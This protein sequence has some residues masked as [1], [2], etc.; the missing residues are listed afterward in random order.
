MLS[1]QDV[2]KTTPTTQNISVKTRNKNLSND[3]CE[4]IRFHILFVECFSSTHQA[5]SCGTSDL[6]WI[7]SRHATDGIECCDNRSTV[8]FQ[9]SNDRTDEVRGESKGNTVSASDTKGK[10][11]TFFHKEKLKSNLQMFLL[12]FC[13]FL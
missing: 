13:D 1:L 5:L 11:G 2:N 12:S 6:V 3:F 7:R 10:L 8:S 4:F 9:T